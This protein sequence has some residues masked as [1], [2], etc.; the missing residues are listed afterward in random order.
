MKVKQE[1]SYL[2]CFLALTFLFVVAELFLTLY[3]LFGIGSA[4][5]GDLNFT[6]TQRVDTLH[7]RPISQ[8]APSQQVPSQQVP[9]ISEPN[10]NI[11]VGRNPFS[12]S[13]S[14]QG[15]LSEPL[16]THEVQFV[17]SNHNLGQQDGEGGKKRKQSQVDCILGEYLEFKKD[18][19]TMNLE[20]LKEKKR[21]EEEFSVANCVDVLEAMD[22]LTDEQKADALELFKC[23][24]NRQLFI[25][26][27]NPN[28]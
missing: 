13:F 8:Q 7:E 17:Q 3:V 11:D 15:A 24:L 23:D 2:V 27:K 26:T 16:E 25:K 4:A 6:S 20:D 19:S 14:G 12:T 21:H 18:Q 10:D 1:I 28:V 22:D 5:T 9:R